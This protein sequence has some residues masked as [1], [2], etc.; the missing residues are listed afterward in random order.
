MAVSEEKLNAFIGKAIGDLGAS[1]SAVLISIG[2]ELGHSIER[3]GFRDATDPD[4]NDDSVSDQVTPETTD[5]E[6]EHP[7]DTK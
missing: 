7:H 4:S 2:D 6:P 3:L 1:M 5:P